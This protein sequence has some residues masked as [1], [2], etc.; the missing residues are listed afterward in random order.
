MAGV[1]GPRFSNYDTKGIPIVD[2]DNVAW[3]Y[4]RKGD[5][6]E[7]LKCWPESYLTQ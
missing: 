5:R 6:E 2:T 3:T 4:D 1:L 7:T